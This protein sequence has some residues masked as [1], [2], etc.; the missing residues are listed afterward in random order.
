M[1]L[2]SSKLWKYTIIM[3]IIN[4]IPKPCISKVLYIKKFKNIINCGLELR[5]VTTCIHFTKSIQC[6][7][8]WQFH[9]KITEPLLGL[10]MR[11]M[12]A[13]F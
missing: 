12:H 5:M 8:I 9:Q 4:V 1:L 7:K 11:R 3:I 10:T 6:T 13:N 2:L